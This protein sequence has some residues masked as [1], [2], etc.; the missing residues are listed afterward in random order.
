MTKSPRIVAL[1]ATLLLSTAA[2]A[3][4]GD[5]SKIDVNADGKLTF[6]EGMKL[7]PEWTAEAFKSLDTNADG[8]L[9]ELEYETAVTAAPAVNDPAAA[10]AATDPAVPAT[11]QTGSITQPT[12]IAAKTGPASYLDAAG[13]NDVLASSLIGMRVYAVQADVDATKAYP[14]EARKEWSDV[15]EVNDVVLDWN[16]DVKAVVLGVGGFLGIGEKN[17]AIEMASLR[18]VRESNDS[19]D[20]FLVVNSSKEML[21]NAPAYATNPKS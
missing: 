12:T 4:T 3:A 5:F 14:A 19:N 21:T 20:W 2:F 13:P 1:A 6:E 8:S 11:D 10:P 15:G 18:K 9:N 16:G 7:H 17:V